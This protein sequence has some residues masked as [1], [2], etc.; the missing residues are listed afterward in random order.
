[1][2][3]IVL[4]KSNHADVDAFVSA[5]VMI[6]KLRLMVSKRWVRRVSGSEEEPVF[7]VVDLDRAVS[8]PGNFVCLL[9]K[10][11]KA[12]PSASSKFFKIYGEESSQIAMSLLTKALGNEDDELVKRE[13]ESRLRVLEPKTAISA[14]CVVCGCVF[15]PKKWGR[16]WGRV[17]PKCKQ[18]NSNSSNC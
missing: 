3:C 18:T 11:L 17:C 5:H 2:A 1:V 7:A 9:P 13:I 14:K 15:E 4:W 8:Y 16:F 12:G 10:F 6:M